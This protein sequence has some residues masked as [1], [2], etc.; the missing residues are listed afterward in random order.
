MWPDAFTNDA[1][2]LQTLTTVINERD[3]IPGRVGELAFSGVAQ[4]V[5]TTSV[6]MESIG[7]AISLVPTTPRGAPAPQD[8]RERATL[9]SLR[10]PQIKIEE[11]IGVHSVQNVREFGTTSTLRG[12]RSI[13]DQQMERKGLRFDLTL[14]HHRLGAVKGLI[15]DADGSELTNLYDAFGVEEPDAIDFSDVFTLG[16]TE[17]TLETVRGRVHEVTRYMRRNIKANWPGSAMIWAL[18]GDNFFDRLV[19]SS[20]VK[21]VWD[22]WAA[23]ERRLGGSYAFGVYEFAGVMWENYQGTDDGG[24]VNPDQVNDGAG[25]VGIHPNE[26][27]F[28]P[29]GVPGLYEEFYAPA[30]F[31]ETVNTVGLPRYAKVARDQEFQRWVKLHMQMNPLPICTRPRVLVRGTWNDAPTD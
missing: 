17:E 1:F 7:G 19:D 6:D 29:V 31:E 16:A 30:D 15:L 12:M 28:F 14:E 22:G 10:I 21:G 18:A 24:G 9:R 3:Y 26:A 23:A 27:R 20:T 2:S 5:A 25:T 13:I 11:T 4:G 8:R